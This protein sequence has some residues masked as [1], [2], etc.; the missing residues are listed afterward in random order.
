MESDQLP[1][2]PLPLLDQHLGINRSGT[3]GADIAAGELVVVGLAKLFA[4]RTANEQGFFF[5]WLFHEKHSN[6]C[7][8]DT[9]AAETFLERSEELLCPRRLC[10]KYF[11]RLFPTKLH[12]SSR[13]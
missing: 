5:F 11:Q 13:K 1:H 8:R 10:G 3:Q 2:P 4:V 9:E 6:C 12:E 7:H